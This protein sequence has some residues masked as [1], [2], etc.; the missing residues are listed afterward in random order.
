MM[1]DVYSADESFVTGTFSGITPV[2]KIDS[3]KISKSKIGPITN[4]LQKLYEKKIHN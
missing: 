4:K 1:N 3:I 2:I